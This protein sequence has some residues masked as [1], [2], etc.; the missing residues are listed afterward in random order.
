MIRLQLLGLQQ[1][2]REGGESLHSV[3]GQ[4]K[5]FALLAY[6]A[7]AAEVFVRRDTVLLIFWPEL[8]QFAARRALRNTVYQLRREL[9]VDVFRTR[10]DEEIGIDGNVL[11]CDVTAFRAALERGDLEDAAT[12]YRGEFLR[13]FQLSGDQEEFDAWLRAERERLEGQAL[14]ALDALVTRDQQAGRLADAVRWSSRAQ[15]IVPS[16][17]R[18]AQ[19]TKAL[20]AADRNTP[21]ETRGDLAPLSVAALPQVA[22]H[23]PPS[24]G[25]R[26]S[27]RT[28]SYAVAAIACIGLTIGVFGALATR[29]ARTRLDQHRLVVTVFEN[30]TGDPRLE[31][32]GNMAAD[33]ISRGLFAA[34]LGEVVDPAVLAI[35]GRDA[36]GRPVDPI[37]LARLTGAG[38]IVEGYYYRSSDSVLFAVSVAD[39]NSG[40][41]TG[42]VAPVGGP[43]ARPAAAL[44]DVRSRVMTA[45]S[46]ALDPRFAERPHM[47]QPPPFPAYN[48]YLRGSDAFWLGEYQQAAQLFREAIKRDSGFSQA[49]VALATV[50]ANARDCA[51]T[52]SVVRSWPPE[53]GG[54]SEADRMTLAIAVANCRGQVDEMFRLTMARAHLLPR[55]SAALMSSAD[56]S[57]WADRP[58]ETLA[59]LDRINPDIDLAWMPDSSHVGFFQARA[60]ADH[61][62]GRYSDQLTEA[63][64]IR[65]V[66]P[67]A[68]TLMRA[69]A[70]V[71]LGKWR[72]AMAAVDSM[73][74]MPA[75]PAMYWGLVPGTEG[76]PEY[77]ATAG[78]SMAWVAREFYAHGDSSDGRAAANRALTWAERLNSAQQATPEV[79]FLLATT[80]DMVGDYAG[81]RAGLLALL[82]SDSANVDARGL[83][84]G[85]DAG[86]G[87]TA[88]ANAGD[89][90]LSHL[91]PAHAGWAASLYRA[92]VAAREHK[93]DDAIR[94][95][96]ESR[97][98]GA[99]P[100]W[101]HSDPAVYSLQGRLDFQA[102]MAPKR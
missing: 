17:D 67:L 9:G 19:R 56:A 34:G 23:A 12:L 38:T 3:V 45:L 92:R 68:G 73:P 5:R 30:R 13:G 102:L 15:E 50:A 37:Q 41:I 74:T 87:D 18:W 101:V 72:D 79:R 29:R 48:D 24:E 83:L 58:T 7:V 53:R 80:R 85:A 82:A 66:A 64:R 20:L 94:L 4:P 44:D 77:S 63:E 61:R 88:A 78:W 98:S 46:L 89:R 57:L 16:D 33:W 62:L 100:I 93:P 14:G 2:E 55:S 91:D 1:L 8:D 81:A 51:L 22:P 25:R 59:I 36:Q 99:W 97:E 70:L 26:A 32:L 28:L 47:A 69:Q 96:R 31:A 43:I 10:G 11:S 42:Q 90:W 84:A 71:G 95:V 76:R 54:L 49:A 6:L 40:R 21:P 75:E 39:A 60:E 86:A 52:D 27:K 35:R 65:Q